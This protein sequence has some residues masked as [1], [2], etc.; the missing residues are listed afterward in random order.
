[1]SACP[2]LVR[3]LP[4]FEDSL[5]Q[6]NSATQRLTTCSLLLKNNHF[7]IPFS[8]LFN[9]RGFPIRYQSLVLKYLQ[10]HNTYNG[11][12]MAQYVLC[13]TEINNVPYARIQF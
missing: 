12:I 13:E 6:D 5:L 8:S 11:Y 7:L 1:M 4:S 9:L 3:L 2:S 10:V